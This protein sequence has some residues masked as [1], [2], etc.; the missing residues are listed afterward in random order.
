MLPGILPGWLG[1]GLAMGMIGLG[2][3][4][5]RVLQND[6]ASPAIAHASRLGM[7]DPNAQAQYDAAN[8]D[9]NKLFDSLQGWGPKVGKWAG[10]VAA[11]L[12]G[13]LMAE[14]AATGIADR[15]GLS[16]LATSSPSSVVRGASTLVPQSAAG[17]RRGAIGRS[18]GPR[19]QVQSP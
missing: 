15:F 19:A 7:A 11:L 9:T 13:S 10:E 12:P 3:G 16:D 1:T 4:A 18:A 2:A 17:A 6:V 8:H 5:S 14:G